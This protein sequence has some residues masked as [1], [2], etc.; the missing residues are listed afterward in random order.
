MVKHCPE[1][2]YKLEKEYKYCPEC[3]FEI[4]KIE[5][6]NKGTENT[7]ST[8]ETDSSSAEKIICDNCGEENDK[9]NMICS[10]CGVKLLPGAA[11]KTAQPVLNKK[12]R[13]SKPA[14][15]KPQ[16]NINNKWKVLKQ[17]KPGVR[18]KKELNTVKT[19]TIV[20]IG[21]GIALVIL[22]FSGVLN[23]IIIPGSSSS[24]SSSSAT[25]N[26]QS[27]GVDLANVQKI[28]DLENVIKNNPKDTASILELAHLKNDAGMFE[29]AIINY[30]QYLALVPT[31]PDARID[32]G[33][34][35]YNLQNYPTAIAEMEQAIKYDPKHQIGYL[36]LGIVNLAAGNF[37]KS[38][39]WLKEAV[40]LDPNS[41]YGKK[42][43]ELLKSHSNQ[44][45]GGQ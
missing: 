1:C 4:K 21:L 44:S 11:E 9:S 43:E 14:E 18:T 35:Y 16:V 2:G 15:K 40:D 31:D 22:I 28:N 37:D 25:N 41:E 13:E 34:C 8:I 10:S 36:D 45:N 20:A 23:S 12:I 19:V 32:M 24:S 38:K 29:Q 17:E 7:A 26:N 39:Q 42:A 5:E 33:I 30:K 27:S 3:G 6:E